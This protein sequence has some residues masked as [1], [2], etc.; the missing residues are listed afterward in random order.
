MN[1]K[2]ACCDSQNWLCV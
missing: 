2:M 1:N